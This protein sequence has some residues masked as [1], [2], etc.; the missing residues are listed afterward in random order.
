MKSDKWYLVLLLVGILLFAGGCGVPQEKYDVVMAER[1]AAKQELATAKDELKDVDIEEELAAIRSQLSALEQDI[2]DLKSKYADLKEDL[3]ES[4]SEP[5]I[6]EEEQQEQEEEL[7]TLWEKKWAQQPSPEN[8][9]H[10]VDNPEDYDVQGLR[11]NADF[12]VDIG[13]WYDNVEEETYWVPAASLGT[14]DNT[15][16]E[17]R[18]LKGK[19]EEARGKINVLFE[20]LAF[21]HLIEPELIH[22]ARTTG[23]DGIGWE[24][25]KPARAAIRDSSLN[26]ASAAN[27]IRYL[28]EDDYDEVGY[29]WRHTSF[30]GSP[31][32]HCTSYIVYNGEYYFFDPVSLA[33]E[34]SKY[35]VEDGDGSGYHSDGCDR[36]IQSTPEKYAIFWTQLAAG[37]DDAIFAMFW[38][39]HNHFALGSDGSNL[40]YPIAFDQSRLKI[41]KDPE[42]SVDLLE[43]S[44]NPEPPKN[45]YGVEDYADYQPYENYV[46]WT[47]P[48][49]EGV[50]QIVA[51]PTDG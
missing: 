40:Y 33:E 30:E 44:Y 16:E 2:D 14:P 24:F 39:P 29:V 36:I 51:M 42:D 46:G 41:W 43:A 31:G 7:Q 15:I 6:P 37:Q 18:Q 49:Q 4:K 50:P 48:N 5:P 22:N 9:K 12:K 26:C 45:Q 1:D 21:I 32:G 38:C 11:V 17:L 25:P 28:L 10:R 34:R 23:P 27:V 35:P 47:G 20:A 13:K 19:P 3:Q 8:T